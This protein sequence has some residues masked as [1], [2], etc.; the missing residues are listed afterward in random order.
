VVADALSVHPVHIAGE[1]LGAHVHRGRV[2]EA[3]AAVAAVV[4]APAQN[5]SYTLAE[6]MGASSVDVPRTTRATNVLHG[7]IPHG[8][9]NPE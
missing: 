7:Y 8:S 4:H 1:T 5:V 3:L 2:L 9:T 6:D